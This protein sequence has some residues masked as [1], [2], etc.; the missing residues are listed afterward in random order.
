MSRDVNKVVLWPFPRFCFDA[1]PRWRN[2]GKVDSAEQGD[3][4]FS[5]EVFED[6]QQR[7]WRIQVTYVVGRTASAC[8]VS[9]RSVKQA[10]W[11]SREGVYREDE[12][13]REE[14]DTP[15]AFYKKCH[16]FLIFQAISFIHTSNKLHC[17]NLFKNA[18]KITNTD[19]VLSILRPKNQGPGLLK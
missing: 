5:S 17:S 1:C 11:L 3:Q 8:R 2:G 16:N 6:E 12:D 18:W 7:G 15:Q 19:W 13:D 14:E 4:C 10:R 9:R